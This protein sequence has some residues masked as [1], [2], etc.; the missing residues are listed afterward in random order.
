MKWTRRPFYCQGTT[1]VLYGSEP[2]TVPHYKEP[3]TFLIEE[4]GDYRIAG[5]QDGSLFTRLADTK[6]VDITVCM[7]WCRGHAKRC[8]DIELER[9]HIIEDVGE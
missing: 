2:I 7:E 8:F 1:H 5:I 9:G 3:I 4:I 6:E